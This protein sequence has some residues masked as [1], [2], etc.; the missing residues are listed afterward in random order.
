[1][2]FAAKSSPERTQVLRHVTDR[3]TVRRLVNINPGRPRKPQHHHLWSPRSES[4]SFSFLKQA[5]GINKPSR[6]RGR[7]EVPPPPPAELEEV[8]P[9]PPE[10]VKRLKPPRRKVPPPPEEVKRMKPPRHKVLP[11]MRAPKVNFEDA[12]FSVK[13]LYQAWQSLGKMAVHLEVQR[14]TDPLQTTVMD[15]AFKV[16]VLARQLLRVVPP[17]RRRWRPR[18]LQLQLRL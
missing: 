16:N 14:P 1:M 13:T 6:K 18:R 7:E 17:P 15:Y 2:I 4:K 12:W 9:P 10:E 11:P 5:H 3:L 8:P